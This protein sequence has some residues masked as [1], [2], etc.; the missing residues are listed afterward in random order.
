LNKGLLEL[1][2]SASLSTWIDYEKLSCAD[3]QGTTLGFEDIT[4]VDGIFG[5]V[6]KGAEKRESHSVLQK[7]ALSYFV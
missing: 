5:T 1:N 3:V 6:G 7:N 4:G 2:F